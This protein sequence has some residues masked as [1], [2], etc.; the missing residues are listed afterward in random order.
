ML[1]SKLLRLR[2]FKD[3]MKKKKD[4][5][6]ITYMQLVIYVKGLQSSCLSLKKAASC[7]L[8]EYMRG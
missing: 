8:I 2:E 5:T 7:W 1:E 6:L 4:Q 3:E